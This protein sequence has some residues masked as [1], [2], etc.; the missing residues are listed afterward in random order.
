MNSVIQ[1]IRRRNFDS[2]LLNT[3]L[4][5]GGND[6]NTCFDLLI[7][8]K[9]HL[10]QLNPPRG[11]ADFRVRDHDNNRVL[12]SRWTDGDWAAFTDLYQQQVNE[13]WDAAFR[14]I[15]PASYT[16]FDHPQTR[17]NP[18]RRN[19]NCGFRV[20]MQLS[21]HS[22]HA[23]IPVVHVATPGTSFRSHAMLY[24][25]NDVS[26]DTYVS[27]TGKID[28]SFFTTVHEVGHLLGLGHSNEKSRQ[29]RQNPYSSIC[30]GATLEQELNVMGRGNML[31]LEDAQPWKQRIA[32]HT[33]TRASDWDAQWQSADA[34]FRGA[35]TINLR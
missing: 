1:E 20:L 24:S 2:T 7:Y 16:G 30:Y 34:A 28:W 3:P 18:S 12:C 35:D 15:T 22:V 32:L 17:P 6:P 5:L 19:V 25:N 10:R 27:A 11:R 31:S 14:L 4:L 21:A 9:V 23:V 33:R 26:P 8:L 29:C 13:F